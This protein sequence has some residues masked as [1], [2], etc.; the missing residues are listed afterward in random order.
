MIKRL[1]KK[2]TIV[3]IATAAIFCA[4][5]NT[6]GSERFS[7][8]FY[9]DKPVAVKDDVEYSVAAAPVVYKNKLYVP[10]D[11]I[12]RL[13]GFTL[14]WDGTSNSTVAVRGDHTN[15]IVFGTK[16]GILW[17]DENRL[18][19]DT[20]PIIHNGVAFI[21]L[22]MFAAISDDSIYIDGSPEF[23]KR[24][25]RDTLENTYVPDNFRLPNSGVKTYNGITLIGNT[26]ME[27][28]SITDSSA[29]AY[30]STVNAVSSALPYVSVYCIAVPTAC[31]FYAPKQLYTNQA[32]GIKKIY[33]LL[34]E[35]VIPINA[36]RPL[37]E[38]AGEFIYFRTDHHWTQRGAYYV[39]REF[40]EN[41]GFD[42]PDLSDFEVRKKYNHV[43]SF[44]SFMSGTPGASVMSSNPDMLEV[45]MP[46]VTAEGAAYN[47]QYLQ[48]YR[49]SL[50][51]VY[52]TFNSYSAFIG[53]DNP[54]AVFH[55]GTANGK[56]L[57]IIKESFGTAFA[58][59]AANNYE[60]I[61][62]I[63][64]REFNG[65]NGKNTA[66]DL[67][68]F[69][70]DNRFDDLVIINYPGTISSSSYRSSVLKM[71]SQS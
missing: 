65:F 58:T 8:L 11:D 17:H 9:S 28:L 26:A 32:A 44:K 21:S 25:M 37:A 55:T 45:F 18:E 59:W 2:L 52:P 61:F 4:F 60:Y 63:D 43:G 47:D 66:F 29:E 68:K 57:V 27:L 39:Y 12:L 48:R 19:F 22:E 24:D 49:T 51:L 71:I 6:H 41:K 33:S 7:V 69:Y 20:P 35:K 16:E 3:S 36:V 13:C 62:V 46:K 38:H 67:K 30:A 5:L 50:Q 53:G 31:E 14:G 10:S 40:A 64:P 54:L 1:L 23:L 34:D 56:K 70:I 15:Y 42:L